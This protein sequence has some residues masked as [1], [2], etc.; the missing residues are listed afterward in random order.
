MNDLK[1]SKKGY[2]K[3]TQFQLRPI[4]NKLVIDMAGQ[5]Y[6]WFYV[7]MSTKMSS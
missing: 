7:D 3:V 5:Y 1:K 6:R 4:E 2:D